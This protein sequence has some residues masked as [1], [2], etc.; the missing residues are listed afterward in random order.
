MTKDTEKAFVIIYAEYLRRCKA[1]E[2]KEQA[3]QFTKQQ[4]KGWDAFSSWHPNDVDRSLFELKQNGF[5]RIY[6]Y[7]EAML[8]TEGIQY[9]EKQPREFFQKFT[10]AVKD[11][12][13]LVVPLLSM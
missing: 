5:M 13:A 1:G 4:I 12:L 11:I 8:T 10:E 2:S 7:G 6:V 9:M 3:S